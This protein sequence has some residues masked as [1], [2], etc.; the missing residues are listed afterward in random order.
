VPA[1]GERVGQHAHGVPRRPIQTAQHI[2]DGDGAVAA[3]AGR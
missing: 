2:K 1:V 3:L